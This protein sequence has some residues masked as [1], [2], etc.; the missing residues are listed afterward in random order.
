MVR[1]RSKNPEKRKQILDAATRLFTDQGYAATSMD[2]IAKKADVSKQTVYSHFGNKDE[3]FM[4]AIEQKCDSYHMLDISMDDLSDPKGILL[5]LAQRF[6]TMLISKEAL[7]VHKICAFESKSYP[8]IAELFF[9]AGPERLSGKV[10]QLMSKF[11][12]QKILKID[13]PKFAAWQFLNMVKGE[14]FVR[15][16]FNTDKQLTEEEVEQYLEASV[17]LFLRGYAWQG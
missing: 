11:N 2:H 13:N 1:N 6:L 3:L 14:N 12:E 4:A 16:E 7:A 5:T 10:A 15:V 8:N 9:K 17:D